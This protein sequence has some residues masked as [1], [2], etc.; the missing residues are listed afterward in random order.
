MRGYA[1]T[2]IPNMEIIEAKYLHLPKLFSCSTVFMDLIMKH[3]VA[4]L[5]S[6]S[7]YYSYCRW[8][9]GGRQA[10]VFL[11]FDI[12]FKFLHQTYRFKIS[13]YLICNNRYRPEKHIS[14]DR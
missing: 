1:I 11:N 6:L 14:V 10:L 8:M 3:T 2:H 13:V 7:L 9:H 12:K 4:P 5:L